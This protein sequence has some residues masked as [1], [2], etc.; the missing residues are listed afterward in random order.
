MKLSSREH[1]HRA[2]INQSCKTTP[3]YND[4]DDD[5]DDNDDDDDRAS[6]A[7]VGSRETYCESV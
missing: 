5:D 6:A 4:E 7:R 1:L 2:L 3:S